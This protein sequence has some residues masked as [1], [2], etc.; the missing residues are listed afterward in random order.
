MA[1]SAGIAATAWWEPVTE[2][3]RQQLP[4]ITMGVLGIMLAFGI[5]VK[6]QLNKSKFKLQ[7]DQDEWDMVKGY[8][9]RVPELQRKIEELREEN[10][11]LRLR[12][13]KLES[14]L[15][16]ERAQAEEA[17]ERADIAEKKLEEIAK[18]A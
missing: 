17:R 1:A 13:A 3:I 9:E 11:D 16:K 14:E 7:R 18:S 12:I 4:E 15:E 8:A 6:T 5:W 2:I 10:L